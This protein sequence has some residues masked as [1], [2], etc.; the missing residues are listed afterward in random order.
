[1]VKNIILSIVLLQVIIDSFW[2]LHYIIN[3]CS[4]HSILNI[5]AIDEAHLTIQVLIR[6]ALRLFQHNQA[7]SSEIVFFMM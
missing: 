4:F 3:R 7:S 1:M 5:S 6:L 2:S